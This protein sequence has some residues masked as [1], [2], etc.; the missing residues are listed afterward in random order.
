MFMFGM[1]SEKNG[2]K[3]GLL[4]LSLSLSLSFG[5]HKQDAKTTSS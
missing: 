1:D 5:Q 3:M 4:S 2:P